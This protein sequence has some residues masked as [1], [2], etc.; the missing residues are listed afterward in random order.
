L[1]WRIHRATARN[2]WHFGPV[3]GTYE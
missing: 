2:D 3:Y 1:W